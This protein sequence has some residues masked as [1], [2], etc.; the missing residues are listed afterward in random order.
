M[1][2]MS[3]LALSLAISPSAGFA[4]SRTM[5]AIRSRICF[6]WRSTRT[7]SACLGQTRAALVFFQDSPQRFGIA[8]LIRGFRFRREQVE[9]LAIRLI[10]GE[11]RM[12]SLR[13]F[14]VQVSSCTH[15]VDNGGLLR[16]TCR[17]ATQAAARRPVVCDSGLGCTENRVSA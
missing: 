2:A 13:S 3:A 6:N 15:P 9:S 7:R 11:V 17:L 12:D 5:A 14:S 10:C 8:S 16:S 4:T 1:A